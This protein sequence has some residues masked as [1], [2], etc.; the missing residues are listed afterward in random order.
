MER[1][2]HS[3][4]RHHR[5]AES[6]NHYSHDEA[7][8]T[9]PPVE[10]NLNLVDFPPPPSGPRIPST[11][12][13]MDELREATY[14]YVNHPDPAESAA[15]RQRVLDGEVHGMMAK[16]AA[17]IVASAAE[18]V[19]L[20]LNPTEEAAEEPLRIQQ[21]ASAQT[22]VLPPPPELGPET[23][24]GDK[25]P[26]IPKRRN[27]TSRTLLGSSS[28]KTSRL[29]VQRSPALVTTNASPAQ[30][31]RRTPSGSIRRTSSSRQRR[32]AQTTPSLNQN[33]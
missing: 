22:S 19:G 7:P 10:R 13:V 31:P 1:Q 3:P 9:R 8:P 27:A 18:A 23:L 14:Q 11:E 32:A 25:R 26:P 17:S 5:S 16:T 15:R 29:R 28:R 4:G 33:W 24:R 6:D 30:L 21:E 2:R 12:E 20:D